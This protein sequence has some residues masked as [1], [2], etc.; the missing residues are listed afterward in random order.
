MPGLPHSAALGREASENFDGR[1][2]KRRCI[3]GHNTKRPK[4]SAAMPELPRGTLPVLHTDIENST[5]LT[6]H[7][8]DRYPE[9][10]APHGALLR[11]AFAAHEGCEID[12]QGDSLAASRSSRPS[13]SRGQLSPVRCSCLTPSKSWW[14]GPASPSR[15]GGL[16]SLGDCQGSGGSSRLTSPRR[17]LPSHN[18][19]EE[20]TVMQQKTPGF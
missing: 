6:V 5:P 9:V 16:T 4:G 12:T 1:A 3:S 13:A 19:P 20:A 15:I 7:L 2:T 11:A 8:G 10:L 14:P 17:A 18:A